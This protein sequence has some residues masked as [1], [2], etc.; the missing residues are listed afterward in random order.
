MRCLGRLVFGVVLLL[1][2]AAGW[3]YRDELLRWGR[4]L[5]DPMAAARRTGH[6]SAEAERAA[7]RKVDALL[8]ER[9]D[10]ILLSADEMASLVARGA[11][12]LPDQ[13][14]DSI[15]VELGDRSLRIRT[16]VN[17]ARLPQRARDYLPLQPAPF[18]EVIASG[19]L[20]PVR[21]GLAEL[22]LERVLVR[23]LPVPS[24]VVGRV[25][26]KVTGRGSDGRLEIAMPR[27]VTGFRVRPDGVA[28]YRTGRGR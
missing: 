12:I 1:L 11:Q 26:G 27:G 8:R 2:L 20:T 17:T 22:R 19:T 24:D 15:S 25:L 3:L 21:D 5:R 18:E 13:P 9:P 10:S 4:D 7:F 6:P 28:I 14:L 23:G 16:M